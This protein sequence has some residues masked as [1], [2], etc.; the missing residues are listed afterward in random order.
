[1]PL[2]LVCPPCA[3]CAAAYGVTPL[4]IVQCTAVLGCNRPLTAATI[5][6]CA[7]LCWVDCFPSVFEPPPPPP[8]SLP[9]TPQPSFNPT[10]DAT[11]AK[12]SCLNC[13]CTE[14]NI[15]YSNLG[16]SGF[17][18]Q[19]LYPT[20]LTLFSKAMLDA[21]GAPPKGEAQ[22]QVSDADRASKCPW[23]VPAAKSG[24]GNVVGMPVGALAA[25][26]LLLLALL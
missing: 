9:Y 2:A 13:K 14:F 16:K 21:R 22:C 15:H 3:C 10:A 11:T 8:P 25:V 23:T 7:M 5:G 1:M 24:A 12:A 19:C 4:Y 18:P 26:V 17:V 20:T 6:N